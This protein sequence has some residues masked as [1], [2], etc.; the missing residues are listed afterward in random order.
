MNSSRPLVHHRLSREPI[1][2]KWLNLRSVLR[3]VIAVVLAG[4][5][6]SPARPVLAALP[7]ATITVNTTA[8]EN[9]TNLANCSLREAIR[10]A[11][12]DTA[13]G[14][15]PAGSGADTI[16]LPAGTYT[17]S[18]ANAG[19]VNEDNNATG[20]LDVLSSMTI[21][22]AGAATTVIQ[23]GTNTSNGIDKVFA[24]NPI[25]TS[26]I[27]VTID[28]VTIRFGRNTQP[29][30]A[31]DFS[32]TGGG[33]DWCGFGTGSFNF[34][35]SIVSSNTNVN[36]YG[37]GLNLD[38]AKPY[39]GAINITNVTFQNN[40][41]VG[42]TGGQSTG[43]AINIFGDQPNVTIANST[44][45]TNL[46]TPTT[47]GGGAIYYRPTNGGSLSIHNSDINS[48]TSGGIGG[49][50]YV[51]IPSAFAAGAI[52]TIDQGTQIRNNVSGGVAGGSA[53]GSG[54][55]L[56]GA[57][58]TT[59]PILISKVTIS[60]NSE[61]NLSNS[62]NRQG[63][64]GILVQLANVTIQ[65]SRIVNNTVLSANGGTG[66]YKNTDIGTVT[67]SNNW[68]GCSTGP[69]AAPCDTAVIVGG[70]AGSLTATPYLR[71]LTT[72]VPS[73]INAGQ[74]SAITASFTT[75]SAGTDVSANLDR[76]IGLPVTWSAVHGSFSGPQTTL[77]A[78][79]TATATFTQDNTCNASSATAQVDNGPAM[80]AITVQC[81]DLTVT[82]SNNVSGATTLPAGW[83]WT[84]HVAN[85]GVATASFATGSTI[86]TDNLPNVS[87]S[88]GAP[89]V[90]NPSG[91]TGTINCSI[92]GTF[93]LACTANGAVQLN[94]GGSFDVQ[95]TATPGSIGTFANPRAAGVCQIDPGGIVPE[96]NEANNTCSNSVAVAP[97]PSTYVDPAGNC[98]G[99]TPC[100]TSV[101]TALNNTAA[102]GT[103]TISGTY[104]IA[105]SLI[106]ANSGANN[107]TLG[108][109]GTLNWIGGAGALVTIGA[110]NVTLKG[111]NLTNAPTVFNRTGVG[112]LTA[113]ANNI[114]AFTIAYTGAGTPAIGHNFWGTSDPLAVAPS[115]IS[116]GE[117]A[118]RLGAPRVTWAEGVGSAM[119]IT[120]SLSGGTGTAV[121]VSHGRGLANAPFGNGLTPYAN[122]MCS[123]YYDVFTIGGSGTWTGQVPVDNTANCNTNTLNARKIFWITSTLSACSPASSTG[124][125]GLVPTTS[126]TVN[127]SGQNLVISGLTV[128]QLGGTAFVAGDPSGN[129]PTAV[130]L[131]GFSGTSASPDLGRL[132]LL[133]GLSAGSLGLL[134]GR[135]RRTRTPA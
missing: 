51:N 101:Q 5:A 71:L 19:G 104:N 106:S 9:G 97:S 21:Q 10:A 34:T 122:Q 37:G 47:S 62:A 131:R 8:D 2:F 88:Y 53:G 93:D 38:S 132:V 70:S 50:I 48:N 77:Q 72:A 116:V 13:Y 69:S 16:T 76:L 29:S 24:L 130:T 105:A 121:I 44:F 110:G 85:G 31:S 11:N 102:N 120:A 117:W 83:T 108:G 14:G 35:N 3:L 27:N 78:N 68:W 40:T 99:N 98:A 57:A 86:L 28:G 55:L 128:A 127:I 17:L 75:N 58:L 20:D 126:L 26:A 73:T 30:G 15:C 66:L 114:T 123:D 119:L 92:N 33:L 82:K 100:F 18:L 7:L 45:T 67:A 59:S 111:L 89:S 42:A 125:W 84:I 4:M 65:Y 63:G 113:Y 81:P 94:A 12:T 112:T 79:G 46:T 124:C 91:L 96:T 134:I 39:T 133:F 103:V 107:V 80:A 56:S 74:T 32:F 54:L 49:G 43:G 23:A 118:K 64:G 60:G 25:C 52:V 22:G 135:L 36:G 41:T 129:D 109:T 90:S 61:S 1:I 6:F 87:A 115:G 95:F